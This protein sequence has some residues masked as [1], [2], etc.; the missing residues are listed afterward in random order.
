M[1]INVLIYESLLINVAMPYTLYIVIFL[2][3]SAMVRATSLCFAI[4]AV[5]MCMSKRFN[6][7]PES[8]EEMKLKNVWFEG[9]DKISEN[10][11][12]PKSFDR[13]K[14]TDVIIHGYL[15]DTS[16][17]AIRNLA[18]TLRQVE[19][20]HFFIYLY[21]LF[22]QTLVRYHNYNRKMFTCRV[23]TCWERL[24]IN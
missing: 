19:V 8:P 4:L 7:R 24:N 15:V 14:E 22:F 20:F 1:I 18:D 10:T 2:C 11:A 3:K 9:V 23:L 13:T 21:S 6:K 5:K 17:P 12:L 16:L